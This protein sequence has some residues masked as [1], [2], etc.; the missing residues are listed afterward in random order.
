MQ[1]TNP[2]EAETSR[3]LTD[4][5]LPRP[6][7]LLIFYEGVWEYGDY[8]WTWWHAFLLLVVLAHLPH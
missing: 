6:N 5:R 8:P 1:I 3:S 4:P 2:R 7:W